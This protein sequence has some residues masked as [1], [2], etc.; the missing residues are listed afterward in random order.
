MAGLRRREI[1][2]LEWSSFRWDCNE[3]EIKPTKHFAPKSEDRYG[4]VTIDAK[5][6]SIFRRHDGDVARRYGEFAQGLDQEHLAQFA[7][8]LT[9]LAGGGSS[10]GAVL[11]V[12]FLPRP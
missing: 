4:V 10:C 6:M 11:A 2:L 12:F 8:L 5:L 1:D 9:E 3:I 7:N